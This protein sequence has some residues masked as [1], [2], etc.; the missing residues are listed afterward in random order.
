MK[1]LITAELEHNRQRLAVPGTV[2]PEYAAW[3]EW[4]AKINH[5]AFGLTFDS[6]ETGPLADGRYGS[7]KVAEAISH[8][9]DDFLL[10]I[11]VQHLNAGESVMVVFGESHLMILRSALDSM[12]GAPCYVGSELSR[13]HPMFQLPWR[14]MHA[15]PNPS[16]DR[17]AHD[18]RLACVGAARRL[19]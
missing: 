18:W 10:D 19:I 1:P 4:Y 13:A 6:A 9:H 8:A 2:L 3:P 7:N 16:L 17:P 12:L 14:L 11:I 15:G 5:K